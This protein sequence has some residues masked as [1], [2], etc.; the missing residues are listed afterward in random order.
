[1]QQ[2]Q[3]LKIALVGEFNAGK[4]TLI[5]AILNTQIFKVGILPTTML[6]TQITYA[7]INMLKIE[8]SCHNVSYHHVNQLEYYQ[9]QFKQDDI[10]VTSMTVML[11]HPFL[12]E[13]TLYDT[14]GFA[15]TYEADQEKTKSILSTMDAIFWVISIEQ[16]VTHQQLALIKTILPMFKGRSVCLMNKYDLLNDDDE[17]K[18]ASHHIHQIL[19]DDFDQFYLVSGYQT[20]KARSQDIHQIN[21]IKEYI[22]DNKNQWLMKSQKYQIFVKENERIQK[23]NQ[24]KSNIQKIQ[25][26]LDQL[27]IDLKTNLQNTNQALSNAYSEFI[28]A[29]QI[30]EKNIINSLF[31]NPEIYYVFLDFEYKKRV[32]LSFEQVKYADELLFETYENLLNQF[33]EQIK[34]IFSDEVE[35]RTRFYEKNIENQD[36]L[37]FIHH[38]SSKEKFNLSHFFELIHTEILAYHLTNQISFVSSDIYQ[39]AY[40]I[41]VMELKRRDFSFEIVKEVFEDSTIFTNLHQ[42][43]YDDLQDINHKSNIQNELALNHIDQKIKDFISKLR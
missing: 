3:T 5:N 41:K 22:F 30:L 4:T 17:I 21:Q 26:N 20:M 18:K 6:P 11:D 33:L 9:H 43:I 7:N 14:P 25:T 27:K 36:F 37:K 10:T 2:S 16:L 42:K 29:Y 23:L 8:D 34:K 38:P 19:K 35:Y 12:K 1:M 24:E 32:C 15:A 28:N 13:I 39:C 40:R 31:Q